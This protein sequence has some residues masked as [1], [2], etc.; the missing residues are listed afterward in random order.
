M[1]VLVAYSASIKFRLN[2]YLGTIIGML[3]LHPTF[4]SLVS[5][6][7]PLKMFGFLPITLANYSST[8]IPI[9]LIIWVASYVDRY[10]ERFVLSQ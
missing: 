9:I 10:V 5:E 8:V 1:P 2:P 3:L 6:G 7:K 4:V